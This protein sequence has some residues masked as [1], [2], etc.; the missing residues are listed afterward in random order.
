MLRQIIH[1][2]IVNFYT[3]VETVANPKLKEY[4]VAVA[5]AGSGLRV[6]LDVSRQGREAGVY[7]GMLVNAAKRRC[8][9][10]IVM[11]PSPEIY[12]RAA[13]G[14]L[15]TAAQFSPLVEYAG[16]GHVFVDITGTQRLF[17]RYIDLADKLHREVKR[18]YNLGN[19]AGLA[20]NKLVSK[21]ATRVVKPSG[22]CTVVNGCEESFMAPLPI[23][24]LP[25]I[26]NTVIRRLCQ[27]NIRYINEILRIPQPQLISVVGAVAKDVYR[28]CRGIDDNPVKQIEKPEAEIEEGG[29]LAQQ[30]ND[31]TVIIK[32]LFRQVCSAGMK[33]RALGYAAGTLQMRITYSDGIQ[34]SRSAKLNS[35]LNG[36]L[37]LFAHFE[38]LFLAVY[39]RRVRLSHVY[40]RLAGFTYPYGQL[41]LFGQQQREEQLMGALDDIRKRYG[42]EVISFGG[43]PK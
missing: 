42:S 21:I 35:P 43:I 20:A 26:D 34:N 28:F 31:E 27:F 4:P 40:V 13:Q 25:G 23:N 32:E 1:I 29:A 24:L 22:L 18:R 33:L 16:P 7:K 14:L 39:T 3:T 10:L 17:G 15:D 19:S 41:D 8:P 6:V 38:K 5:T 2:N 30:T 11:N 37:S 36:D 9:D 12:R